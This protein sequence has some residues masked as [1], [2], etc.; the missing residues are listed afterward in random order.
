MYV[1][2]IHVYIST[3]TLLYS[4]L[5][6]PAERSETGQVPCCCV[7]VCGGVFAINQSINESINQS[8][9]ATHMG[10][11]NIYIYNYKLSFH[12]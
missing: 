12:M 9:C 3:S 5:V 7:C 6:I 8:P 10:N 11:I 2:Y 4:T 1:M